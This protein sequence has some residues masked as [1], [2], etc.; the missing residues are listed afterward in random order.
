[1]K[2]QHLSQ[3]FWEVL[4]SP[5]CLPESKDKVVNVVC[6]IERASC[7]TGRARPAAAGSRALALGGSSE[8]LLFH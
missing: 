8:V 7:T 3:Y 4:P 1:M 5:A 6:S 2:V